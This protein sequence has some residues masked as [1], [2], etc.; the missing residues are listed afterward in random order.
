MWTQ[1]YS[2]SALQ[3]LL[4]SDQLSSNRI[5]SELC[6]HG[7][8]LRRFRLCILLEYTFRTLAYVKNGR[9]FGYK[10]GRYISDLQSCLK[11][12][13]LSNS[14]AYGDS[15]LHDVSLLMIFCIYPLKLFGIE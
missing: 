15:V 14:R 10:I 5:V 13:I 11:C 7:G 6:E 9:H 1:S 2:N 12:N 4:S 3:L 8:H